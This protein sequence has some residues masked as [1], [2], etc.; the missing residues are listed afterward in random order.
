MEILKTRPVFEDELI[1]KRKEMKNDIFNNEGVREEE[2]KYEIIKIEINCKKKV[3]V[4][5]DKR[6]SRSVPKKYGVYVI[7]FINGKRYVGFSK[8]LRDRI[9][10]H[11]TVAYRCNRDIEYVTIYLTENMSDAL[12]LEQWLIKTLKPNIKHT[13]EEFG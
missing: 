4:F 11:E 8:N 1:E 5:N 12:V 7:N 6:Y 2:E 10:Q 9:Y 3:I 13:M